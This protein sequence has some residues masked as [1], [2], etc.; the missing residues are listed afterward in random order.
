MKAV[1]DEMV[2]LWIKEVEELETKLR[3][4]R[5]KIAAAKVLGLGISAEESVRVRFQDEISEVRQRLAE[6]M[7]QRDEEPV[8]DAIVRALSAHRGSWLEPRFIRHWLEESGFDVGR[9]GQN[10]NYFYTALTRLV[11]R[12]IIE[13]NEETGGYRVT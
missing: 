11:E 7:Q 6:K 10:A 3:G 9:F 5:E 13:K 4:L 8:T 12:G 1:T 2:R